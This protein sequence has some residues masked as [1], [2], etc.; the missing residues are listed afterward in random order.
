MSYK[1]TY[2][3]IEQFIDDTRLYNIY[4]ICFISRHK[5]YRT[6]LIVAIGFL[7]SRIL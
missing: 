7:K 5:I 4:F 6:A 3:I 2:C 1:Y